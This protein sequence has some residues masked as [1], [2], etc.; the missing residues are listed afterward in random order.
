MKNVIKVT[1]VVV[2]LLIVAA[3]VFI[4]M[5]L[6]KN[7]C[8]RRR[9]IQN[10]NE[11]GEKQTVTIKRGV[12]SSEYASVKAKLVSYEMM[13]NSSDSTIIAL[14]NEVKNAKKNLE[15]FTHV[16]NEFRGTIQAPV[17]DTPYIYNGE[18][19][20]AKS[21]SYGDKWANIN[22]LL[23]GDSVKLDY[24]IRNEFTVS[25][26]WKPTGFLN[27]GKKE[28]TVTVHSLN[29]NTYTVGMTSYQIQDRRKKFYETR[30]FSFG[31]GLVIG[32]VGG[33]KL[34]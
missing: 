11:Y 2:W 26:Y 9:D 31:M 8:N 4:L 6:F 22:G 7:G 3:A 16:K 13:K 17:V 33:N 14:R 15:H 1:S 10:Y 24:V 18:E 20:L 5:T 19:I 32:L 28:L 21:F 25:S 34:K 27:L 29:P 23:R 12:D 30:A